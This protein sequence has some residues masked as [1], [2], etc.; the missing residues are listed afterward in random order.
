MNYFNNLRIRAKLLWAFAALTVLVA[1]FGAAQ[2]TLVE[3]I[4]VKLDELAFNRLPSVVALTEIQDGHWRIHAD[5]AQ[6][7]ESTSADEAARLQADIDQVWT[8]IDAAWAVYEP[9]YQTPEEAAMWS[10]FTPLWEA[11]K[12]ESKALHAPP[13]QTFADEGVSLDAPA[14]P[15]GFTAEHTQR[16][17][18]AQ[19]M[20][21]KLVAL[22]EKLADDLGAA[23]AA[24]AR[25]VQNAVMALIGLILLAAVAMG[26]FLARI[27]ARPLAGLTGAANRFAEGDYGA[28]A[29]ADRADEIGMLGAAFNKMVGA[30]RAG[31]AELEAEK[32]SVQARVEEAV[33]AAEAEQEYLNE[34]V[35]YMLAGIDQFAA[36]DLLVELHATRD[37]AV[38]RLFEG[39]N[40]A[41]ANLRE[42]I[43]AVRNAADAAATASTQIS[44]SAEQLAGSANEQSS[45]AHEVAAAVEEMVRTIVENSSMATR[46][47]EIAAE[48]GQEAR[49]GGGV[50]HDTV[51]RIRSIA[52]RFQRSTETI[53]RLGERSKQIGQIVGVINEIAD[54]TNLLALNAA[55]EAARAG[56]QGRGFAV[57]ADEVRKLAE[58]TTGATKEIASMIT[59]IQAESEEAIRS[60]HT[61]AGEVEH[62]IRLA[63]AAGQAL[64]RIV[65]SSGR[66]VD[67]VQ[68]IAAASEEQS[69]TSEQIARSVEAISNV[70]HESAQGVSQVAQGAESLSLLTEELHTLVGRFKTERAAPPTAQPAV[71]P[72]RGR[73]FAN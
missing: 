19:A 67:T 9:L 34:R 45:Q 68:Q 69:A 48:A 46:A 43:Q 49:E 26:L 41:A 42:M 1:A 70:S 72:A 2:Y 35:A 21:A 15:V 6:L 22:N 71:R 73:V 5:Q 50:V 18:A 13:L 44:A 54:Q 17:E 30:V 27:I 64:E 28:T 51:E 20:L 36:G 66:S 65:V 12:T 59:T 16:Y 3:G 55:I 33:A 58:R 24:R 47:A 56:E 62:G 31:M 61:G 4:S 39:F 7:I 32:E 60:M 10:A 38:S 11:W 37:D 57:V 29:Q 52:D 25:T 53:E 14:A 63:D 40:R 8:Q 23:S